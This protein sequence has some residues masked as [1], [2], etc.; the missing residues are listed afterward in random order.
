V[1]GVCRL[2]HAAPGPAGGCWSHCG[3]E[4]SFPW[5][6]FAAHAG[7]V[8][9]ATPATA[10]AKTTVRRLPPPAHAHAIL[11]P[12]YSTTATGRDPLDRVAPIR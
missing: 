6:G 1:S 12:Y 11:P 8:A 4:M 9:A 5:G 7:A 3:W 2:L 10:S